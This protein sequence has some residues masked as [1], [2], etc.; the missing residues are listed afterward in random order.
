MNYILSLN[1]QL[2]LFQQSEQQQQQEK[3]KDRIE[4]FL[5][6]AITLARQIMECSS[7]PT[8]V[9]HGELNNARESRYEWSSSLGTPDLSP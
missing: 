2:A 9:R 4:I 8:Y 7:R 6:A 5:F 1:S 3:K